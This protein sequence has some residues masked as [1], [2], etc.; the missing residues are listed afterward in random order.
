MAVAAVLLLGLLGVMVAVL[1]VLFLSPRAKFYSCL[2]V[3]QTLLQLVGGMVVL[4]E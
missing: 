3:L 2:L 4:M 1:K